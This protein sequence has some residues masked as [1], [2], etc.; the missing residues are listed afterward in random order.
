MKISRRIMLLAL[1]LAFCAC[2]LASC[3][4][5]DASS[6]DESSAADESA[7]ESS[8]AESA[9][10][11]ESVAEGNAPAVPEIIESYPMTFT[12]L[13]DSAYKVDCI[14]SD[15]GTLTLTFTEKSWGTFNLGAWKLTTTE[16][17]TLSFGAGATDWEYVYRAGQT[18]DA[19]V[20]SGGNHGN[21]KLISLKFY[22]GGSGK[23][24]SPVSGEATELEKLV[25][26]ENT[27][28]HWGDESVTYA[29]LT[30]TYT[31]I[32]PQIK[33]NVG[34]KY[35]SDC[36]CRLSYTC[37]FPINKQYGLYCDMID[38]DNNIIKTIETLKVGAADYSGA[39]NDG[40]AATRAIIYG[41]VDDRY[42][43]DVRVTTPEDS[44]DGQKNSFKTAFWD[45][46]T[47]DNKLYFSK[48]DANTPTLVK[49]G[50]EFSTE[51]YW[52]F[53]I[54]EE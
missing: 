38:A 31:V 42:K 26:V 18:A 47:T 14:A 22:D 28:L 13:S 49:S 9:E 4:S 2:G 27:Q 54:D 32:G 53:R 10:S 30:R 24:L 3:G 15:G 37:M 17:K 41:Y 19:W 29:D 34:Y 8:A 36:Y 20:W 12:K 6:V 1:A 23:E 45:M 16:N 33:L 5:G 52:C 51:C 50:T 25:I 43:F 21:E 11:A 44:L 48:Y 40:N 35:T 39:M 7:A 46:N